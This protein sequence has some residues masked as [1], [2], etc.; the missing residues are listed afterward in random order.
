MAGRVVDVGFVFRFRKKDSRE[1]L[2][3]KII[4][5]FRMQV[6]LKV[7]A[8]KLKLHILM[9][10]PEEQAGLRRDWGSR[11]YIADI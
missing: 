5:L 9:E 10:V 2:S 6:R 1:C 3:N 4:A 8:A 11:D 7:I